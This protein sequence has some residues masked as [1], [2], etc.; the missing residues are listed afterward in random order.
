MRK[1]K[2]QTAKSLAAKVSVTELGGETPIIAWSEWR[3]F[4]D[5]R[6]LEYLMAPFGPGCYELRDGQQLV[7]FGKSRNVARRMT[8]L[9]PTRF[10]SGTRNN[11]GKRKYVWKHL[12]TI[13]YRTVACAS[14]DEA[15][16]CERQLK[17]KAQE[18]K[19]R[20]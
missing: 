17:A 7:L 6:K 2:Q 1:T 9:L 5:P 20:T 12:P 10:G 3:R 15:D 8:S 16:K 13:K 4:P 11:A 18:Y 14:A 19:F